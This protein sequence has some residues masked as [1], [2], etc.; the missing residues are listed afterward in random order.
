MGGARSGSRNDVRANSESDGVVVGF[1]LPDRLGHVVAVLLRRHE[2]GRGGPRVRRG[3][4]RL[5]RFGLLVVLALAVLV[6]AQQAQRGEAAESGDARDDYTRNLAGGKLIG[7]LL[8]LGAARAD[9]KRAPVFISRDHGLG[10]CLGASMAS[11]DGLGPRREF[12]PARLHVCGYAS[13]ISKET[14]AQLKIF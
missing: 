9:L 1:K 2:V 10:L 3:C 6:R 11:C 7:L 14:N 13:A 5:P 4:G 12:A 8:F